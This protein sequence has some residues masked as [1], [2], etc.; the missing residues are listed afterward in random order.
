VVAQDPNQAERKDEGISWGNLAR[1]L[2]IQAARD[3]AGLGYN[4]EASDMASAKAFFY[5]QGT[6]HIRHREMWFHLA[7]I[8]LPTKETMPRYVGIMAGLRRKTGPKT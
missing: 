8:N 2:L 5:S 4:E 7:G 1:E 6:E 3:V